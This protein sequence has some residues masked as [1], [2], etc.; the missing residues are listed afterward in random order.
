MEQSQKLFSCQ[1]RRKFLITR[2]FLLENNIHIHNWLKIYLIIYIYLCWYHHLDIHKIL[3]L[4]IN[5]YFLPRGRHSAEKNDSFRKLGHM[6]LVWC[7]LLLF[8]NKNQG[9]WTHRWPFRKLETDTYTCFSLLSVYWLQHASVLSACINAC[10][11]AAEARRKKHVHPAVHRLPHCSAEGEG[12]L[13]LRGRHRDHQR[14][15]VRSR[16]GWVSLQT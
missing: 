1:H 15:G 6:P 13:D 8:I 16:W 7:R 5:F 10:V 4:N 11:S 14:L 9:G 12:I 2:F 3:T